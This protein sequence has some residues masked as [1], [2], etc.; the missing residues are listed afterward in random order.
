M[1]VRSEHSLPV[2][3]IYG[4]AGKIQIVGQHDPAVGAGQD[5]RPFRTAQVEPA[6]H[7]ARLVIEDPLEPELAG[8]APRHR[9]RK[10]GRPQT[11]RAVVVQGLAGLFTVPADALPHLCRGIHIF[12]VHPQGLH[13]TLFVEQGHTGLRLLSV[14]RPRFQGKA[15]GAAVQRDR[16]QELR[17]PAAP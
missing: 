11:F 3:N 10:R 12:F 17:L 7:A 14:L 5:G 8:N 1:Q 6:M 9:P 4:I 15:F 13:R 16:Q 2:V